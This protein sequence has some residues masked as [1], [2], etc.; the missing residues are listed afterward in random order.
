MKSM[1]KLF[2]TLALVVAATT[3]MAHP[4]DYVTMRNN[5]RFLTDRMAYTLGLST[6][7]ID[8]LYYINYDYISG[9][10][11]YL[12]DVAMGYY[13]DDYMTVVRQRD[14]ALRRLLTATQWNLLMTYDY[15]YRPISFIDRAWH[16]AIYAFDH[17]HTHF[18]YHTPRHFN[19]YRGG[20][21]FHGMRPTRPHMNAG[22]RPSF[23]F[24][25]H[26]NSRPGNNRIDRPG[27]NGSA[28]GRPS[29]TPG[30]GNNRPG[31]DN[32]QGVR[33]GSTGGRNDA[34][35]SGS[36]GDRN[37]GDRVSTSTS[38]RRSD[39]NMRSSSR[40]GSRSSVT[41]GGS[42]SGTRSNFSTGRSTSGNRSSVS[43]SSGSTT[44]SA[45]ATRGGGSGSS[46][47]GR[48]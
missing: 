30:V 37:R 29:S 4:M 20:H 39:T 13:Y 5:A 14:Y 9:V 27:N 19:T 35:M 8:D 6:A 10:N 45:G 38:T 25:P 17:R 36:T 43:R 33:P 2:A 22:H 21:H 24:E 41:R 42:T 46:R 23:R 28:N 26:G 16:F 40:A 48:R 12:D 18:Y 7:L 3:A 47:S 15:F 32:N 31:T 34:S 44:R 11:D 1:K